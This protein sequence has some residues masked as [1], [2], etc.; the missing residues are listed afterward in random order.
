MKVG[1]ISIETAIGLLEYVIS[2]VCYIDI[3]D[4]TKTEKNIA[5]S[6]KKSNLVKVVEYKSWRCYE[7]I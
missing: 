6:L 5:L 4:L 7:P 3:S 2:Q 1:D